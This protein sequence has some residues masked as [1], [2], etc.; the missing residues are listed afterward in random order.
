[1]YKNK[2]NNGILSDLKKI[3]VHIL[4]TIN[5]IWYNSDTIMILLF[6]W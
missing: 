5:I 2:R 3:H 4:K 6:Y 1:M